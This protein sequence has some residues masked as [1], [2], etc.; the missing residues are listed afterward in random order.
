M[1]SLS[2][3]AKRALALRTHRIYTL[4]ILVLMPYSGC[5]CRC[6]MCDI[7]KSTAVDVLP[8]EAI[9]A[10][11]SALRRLGIEWAVLSGGEALLHPRFDDCCR[12]LRESGVRRISLLSA[13]LLLE[14][15]TREVASLC[16]EVIVS[17]DGGRATHDSIRG[18]VGAYE[19]LDAGIRAVRA[20]DPSL[21]ITGRCVVQ[22]RNYR[23]LPDVIAATRALGLDRISF[24]AADVSATTFDRTTW[25]HNRAAEV[26]LSLDEV[27]EFERVL[28]TT[29]AQ[30]AD[31]LASGLVAESPETLRRMAQ[32]YAALQHA[33][34]FPA[35]RCNAPWVSTVIEAD[36]SVRPCFFQPPLGNVLE[37]PLDEILN[38]P[39]AIEFRRS[40]DIPHNPICCRCV[41]SL[42][43][44]PLASLAQA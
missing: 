33:A 8:V 38:A 18:I 20:L 34:P 10:Q 29:L 30:H 11:G 40:L 27:R 44:R 21:R 39:P 43:L 15:H 1:R 3:V 2:L 32:Y 24:L 16:D 7:W 13:G 5:S 26:A 22:R 37:R 28:D 35:V 36:G 42:Y 12:V 14:Q 6:V 25:D 23:A 41:C 17:L 19:R 4:P 9:R 31:A